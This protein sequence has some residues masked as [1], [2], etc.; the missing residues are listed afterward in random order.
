MGVTRS[1]IAIRRGRGAGLVLPL[2][3]PPGASAEPMERP[4][5]EAGVVAPMG[6]DL[7]LELEVAEDE[8]VAEGAPL[9]NVV[10]PARG[11]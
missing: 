4:T 1:G 11:Y 7:R 5:E 3:T 10:D 8:I 9:A 6:C 2:E